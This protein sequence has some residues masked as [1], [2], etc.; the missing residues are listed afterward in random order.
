MIEEITQEEE[1]IAVGNNTTSMKAQSPWHIG[2]HHQTSEEAQPTQLEETQ[3]IEEDVEYG[4]YLQR[5]QRTIMKNPKYANATLVEDIEEPI[6]YEEESLSK[7]WRK[8]M[9]EEMDALKK[10]Q[11]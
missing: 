6:T 8:A 5:S 10:N 7:E 1:R 4:L 3:D 9:K 11:T 2:V